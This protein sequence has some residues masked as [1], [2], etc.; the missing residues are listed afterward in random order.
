MNILPPDNTKTNCRR[1][2]SFGIGTIKIAGAFFDFSFISCKLF[3]A[4]SDSENVPE[5]CFEGFEIQK[6]LLQ[7]LLKILRFGNISRKVK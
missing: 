1:C 3:W 6:Y 2:F 7:Y 5:I 4:I